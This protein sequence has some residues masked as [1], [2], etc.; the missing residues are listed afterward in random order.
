MAPLPF[1][2][3]KD[4]LPVLSILPD[5]PPHQQRARL[6]EDRYKKYGL[7]LL[8]NLKPGRSHG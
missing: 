8:K 5:I 3:Q 1:R 6:Q 4:L 2:L 7:S